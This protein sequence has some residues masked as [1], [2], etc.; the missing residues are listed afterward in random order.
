VVV[1]RERQHNNSEEPDDIG[2][3]LRRPERAFDMFIRS[4]IARQHLE[5]DE[6]SGGSA[7]R[8]SQ[9]PTW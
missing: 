6:V 5:R 1:L 4:V 3:Y 8:R 9:N 2:R 7:G